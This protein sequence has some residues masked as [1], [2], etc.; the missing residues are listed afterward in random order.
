MLISTHDIL[1]ELIIQEIRS[2]L[3]SV[4]RRNR[5]IAAILNLV[6]LESTS[7]IYLYGY[8]AINKRYFKYLLDASFAYAKS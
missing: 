5:D 1:I 3:K 6:R 8:E 2:Q 7:D 4:T